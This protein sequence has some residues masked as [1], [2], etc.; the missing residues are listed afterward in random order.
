MHRLII[1]NSRIV[2]R[3]KLMEKLLTK[4]L[5]LF[6][7]LIFFLRK[8]HLGRSDQCMTFNIA[9]H[10]FRV[11]FLRLHYDYRLIITNSNATV[12][13]IDAVKSSST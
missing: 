5:L 7:F 9:L 1:D 6:F 10:D 8:A 11:T 12:V 4:I 2:L 3:V 13:K